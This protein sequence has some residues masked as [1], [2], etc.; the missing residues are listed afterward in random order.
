MNEQ[1]REDYLNLINE[2]LQATS[3]SNGAAQIVY[4]LLQANIDKLDDNFAL[5][6]GEGTRAK[7]CEVDPEDAEY[8][9]VVIG[10]FSNRIRDFQLGS[11]ASNLEI[12]ITGFEVIATVFTREVF[13]KDWATTQC[14]L[15]NAYYRRIRGERADNIEV[16][17]CY[18]LA[19]LE[20][21]TYEASPSDWAKTHNNLGLAYSDRIKGE[22]ADNLETAIH[23]FSQALEVYNRQSF[24]SDWASTQNNLGSSYC[25]R[26]RGDKANNLETAIRCF[27]QALEVRT[28]KAFP[29]DWASTQNNLGSAYC[30]RIRGERADNLET[31]IHYFSQALE[32][33]TRKA[34]PEKWADTQNN[35]GLVY[36]YRIREERA[37]N[38]ETAIHYFSQALD[39]YNRTA[40]PEKWAMLQHNLGT[41]YT[42]RIEGEQTENLEEA[43]RCFSNA[44]EIRTRASVPYDRAMTQDNLGIAYRNRI[45][46]DREANLEKAI[47]CFSDAQE[48]FTCESFPDKWAGT[49]NNLGNAYLERVQGDKAENLEAAICCFSNALKIFTCEAFPQ[50]HIITQF[51]LGLAYQNANQFRNA[52]TAFA[53]AID[54]MESQRGEIVTGSGREEDKQ[55][56]AEQWNQLYQGVVKVCVDLHEIAQAV[57]YVERSKARNLIELIINRDRHTIFPTEVVSQLDRLRD[58]IASSQYQL[59]TTTLEDPTSLTQHL[60]QL[61]RMRHDLQDRY[62]SIGSSFKFDRFQASMDDRTAIIEWYITSG[63]FQIFIITRQCSEPIVLSYSASD[64]KALEKWT[65][66]YLRLYYRKNSQWWHHQLT[67]R[68]GKLSQLLRLDNILTHLPEDCDR[69]ILIPNRFL[70]LL[71]L[72]ALPITGKSCLLDRFPQ[73]VG[74]APSCQLLQLVQTR[75]RP[76]FTK[77]FAVQNPT[78]DLLYTDIEVEIIQGYFE[79]TDI[80]IKSAATKPAIH[81]SSLNSIH[82]AHFGCHGYFNFTNPRKSALILAGADF[83]AVTT[84]LDSEKFLSLEDGGLLDLEKCLTL[85]T[86][87]SLNLEQCRLVTLSACETGLIDFR[88]T[89]DEYIGL[90]S[91]FLYVGASSVVSSLWTVN[92]LSTAFLMIRFYQNLQKGL[93][94]GFALNQAQ[95]WLKDLTK[96]DLETW[97]EENQLPLKPAI[98][99]NLRR[100]LYKLEDDTQPFKSPFYWAA[101]CA[102]GQ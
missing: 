6:L 28:R 53:A 5:I 75:Q 25:I 36:L 29:S 55:K 3:E 89:S 32:V 97:I 18:Y 16:A 87:F 19:G 14:N 45:R 26:I 101:F 95:L 27:L 46:G 81:S 84:E 83:K 72:H 67:S 20:I 77:L 66:A 24:P 78:E 23:Y 57:E 98:R 42:D 88:N 44:L 4:P 65:K 33:N 10:N 94:V 71:P 35:L 102:I 13:P 56:L 80:L 85:D 30:I 76:D 39:V 12:A 96:G 50:N 40:F 52:K 61:R 86:I 90:P 11:R 7:L 2:L 34:L 64:Q 17:I 43:I 92:D 9:A 48:V 22:R 79:Q 1:R 93:A 21:K 37:D 73:G 91:G 49:Q 63:S 70:H 51:N 15:G 58:E 69:L 31:A 100:R 54:T 59:Q 74:Y 68:L 47:C 82:C 38:L 8:M 99:M 60:Q 62:L 41:A